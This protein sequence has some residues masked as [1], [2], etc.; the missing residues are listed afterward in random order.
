[1]NPKQGVINITDHPT[2]DINFK[3]QGGKLPFYLKYFNYGK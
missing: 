2:L 3:K 1:M